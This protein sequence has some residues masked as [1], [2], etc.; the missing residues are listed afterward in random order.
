[1]G[2]KRGQDQFVGG[3]VMT[4]A[5]NGAGCI[6]G[7]YR[8]TSGRPEHVQIAERILGRALR[9][10]EGVHHVDGDGVN[11]AHTNLVIFPNP[12]YHFLL[13]K[14]TR[15][16]EACGNPNYEKCTFCGGWDDPSKMDNRKSFWTH[17][18]CHN[19][20]KRDLYKRKYGRK[21]V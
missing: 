15:A 14:R 21:E 2:R 7:G 11:N 13:H 6:S 16:L 9:P 10:G 19:Q 18:D 4:H 8:R 3:F 20:Y 12:K 5:P 1:M 17:R